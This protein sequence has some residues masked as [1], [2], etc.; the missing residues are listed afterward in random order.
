[1]QEVICDHR[2][3]D[4]VVL[5]DQDTHQ[6]P[7]QQAARTR[8]VDQDRVQLSL[9]DEHVVILCEAHLRLKF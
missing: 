3:M 4:I 1:M 5:K 2:D 8:V 7:E 9:W 6:F